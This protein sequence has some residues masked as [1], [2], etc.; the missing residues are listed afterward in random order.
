M[1]LPCSER[2]YYSVAKA[3]TRGCR[4]HEDQQPAPPPSAP[5]DFVQTLRRKFLACIRTRSKWTAADIRP[6]HV[7]RKL[8]IRANGSEERRR[9]H[10]PPLGMTDVR[11]FTC[12]FRGRTKRSD[13]SSQFQFRAPTQR[14][15]S[16]AG[17]V[18]KG[19]ADFRLKSSILIS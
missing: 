11:I 1:R 17:R 16:E 2:Q 15:Q 10:F 5:M 13:A 14:V 8:G 7:L 9:D 18:P 6:K 4:C 19:Q 12:L 3:R